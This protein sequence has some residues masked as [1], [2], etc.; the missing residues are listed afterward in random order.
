MNSYDLD[1]D[2]KEPSFALGARPL[3]GAVWLVGG[4]GKCFSPFFFI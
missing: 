3:T 4:V 1:N 2:I